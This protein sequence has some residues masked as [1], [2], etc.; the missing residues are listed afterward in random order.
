V[1]CG[2][3]CVVVGGGAARGRG[4]HTVCEVENREATSGGVLY[5]HHE[6]VRTWHSTD[7]RVLALPQ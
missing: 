6:Y 4:C 3:M 2:P 7:V 1:V 5:I